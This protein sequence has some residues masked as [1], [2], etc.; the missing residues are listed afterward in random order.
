LCA[1]GIIIPRHNSAE[2]NHT[3]IKTSS[4]S[5][6]YIPI[7]KE[8]NL[9]NSINYLKN[10]G[11]WIVGTEMK[12]SKTIFEMDFKM[13]I[14]LLIGNE[15]KG[16]RK[17]LIDK[18]DFIVRIPMS[19]KLDSMNVSVSTGVFLYEILRQKNA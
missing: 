9:N 16:V 4:G 7:A 11:Y 6:N 10:N 17:S 5:V 13:P 12:A 15:G 19:G 2:V 14:G 3:V 1:D 18:C 8:T